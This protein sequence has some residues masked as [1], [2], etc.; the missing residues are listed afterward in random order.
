M[1][2]NKDNIQKEVIESEIP[3]ILEFYSDSCIPCKALSPI[4][5]EIEDEYEDKIKVCKV[6]VSAEAD[7]AGEYGVMASPTILYFVD[8]EEI[9]RTRGMVSKED[10]LDKIGG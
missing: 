10:I 3:V 9:D 1:R 6:N 8:G 2:I 4:L 5:G 7:L